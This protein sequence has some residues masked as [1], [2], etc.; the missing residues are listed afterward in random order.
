VRSVNCEMSE[1]WSSFRGNRNRSHDEC[2]GDEL[3]IS[4]D[5]QDPDGRP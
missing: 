4:F 1:G 3:M 5:S 2:L